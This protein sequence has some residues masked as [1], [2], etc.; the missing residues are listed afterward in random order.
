MKTFHRVIAAMLIVCVSQAYAEERLPS[1]KEYEPKDGKGRVVV[2]ISGQSGPNNYMSFA[3]DIAAQ[4]YYTVLVDANDFW[5]NDASVDEHRQ[6]GDLLKGVIT[7][8]Q[9]SPRAL[10][11]KVAVIGFSKGGGPSLA[12]AARMPESVAAIVTFYPMTYYIKDPDSFVSKMQVPTL[13]LA[14]VRDTYLKCCLVEKARKLGAAAKPSQGKSIL[15]VVEY[16][17]AD[18][19][20]NLNGSAWRKDDAADALS[21]ALSHVRQYL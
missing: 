21:R 4:G 9:Q 2:V 10:P 6:K 15:E 18:H 11:G 7:R 20:F 13:L 19:G 14:A 5:K 17:D 12:Y 8:A 3:R 1:Q 16:P